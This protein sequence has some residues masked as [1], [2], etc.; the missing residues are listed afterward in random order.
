[1][2]QLAAFAFG[3]LPDINA[4][5]RYTGHSANLSHTQASQYHPQP[6]G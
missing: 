3:V 2:F 5:Y 6:P 1:M 4:F